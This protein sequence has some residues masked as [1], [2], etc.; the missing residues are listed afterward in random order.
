MSVR[1]F[2]ATVFIAT[3]DTS[4]VTTSSDYHS[5]TIEGDT[6]QIHTS[7]VPSTST[8]TGNTGE[9]CW[10]AESGTHYIYLCVATNTW[11]KVAVNV[12]SW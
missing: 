3:D 1:I 8:S 7:R 2:D 10:G 5:L 6:L 9:I 12:T 4:I 11:K